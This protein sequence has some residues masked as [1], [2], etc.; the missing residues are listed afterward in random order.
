MLMQSVFNPVEKRF[1]AGH[2][3]QSF[4]IELEAF[5]DQST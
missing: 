3:Q 2:P 5:C 4:I 1:P